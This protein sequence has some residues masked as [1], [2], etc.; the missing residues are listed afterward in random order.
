MF[1][2]ETAKLGSYEEGGRFAWNLGSILFRLI[3]LSTSGIILFYDSLYF[4]KSQN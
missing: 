1:F 2:R 3:T 4:E